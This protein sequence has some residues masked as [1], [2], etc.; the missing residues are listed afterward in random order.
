MKRFGLIGNP[1]SHSFSKTYFTNKFQ[2]E[3]I[4]DCTYDLY[5]ISSIDT[6]LALIEER[7]LDGINVTIPYKESIIPYLDVLSSEAEA[8]GAAN[9]I[10]RKGNH[11][12]GYNTDCY[13]FERSLLNW[14]EKLPD[15]ALIL[16]DGG[17]S[18]A[19]K[20]VLKKLNI[21]FQIV[22]RKGN[23]NYENL[24]VSLVFE[25][26]LII[27]TTPLGMSPNVNEKVDLPFE[28]IGSQHYIFDLIYNPEETLFLKTCKLA[29][30]N[31]KNGFEMLEL[32]A[33]KSWEIWMT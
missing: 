7:G 24:P 16:G 5:P 4:Y 22:S 23:L 29:G 6:F 13:G 28:A 27:N 32:Q 26:K 10:L 2:R 1:L 17:S 31:T 25:S 30:A 20:Y 15:K 14:I 11:L 21:D 9:C 33:E 18:K 8:I 12:T 3:H 19:V